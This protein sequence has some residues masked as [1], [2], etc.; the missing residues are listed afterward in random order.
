MYIITYEIS[1]KQKIHPMAFV[2][3]I[4]R[5]TANNGLSINCA[6]LIRTRVFSTNA[7]VFATKQ[8]T[9]Y[10]LTTNPPKTVNLWNHNNSTHTTTSLSNYGNADLNNTMSITNKLNVHAVNPRSSNFAHPF[11]TLITGPPPP[12]D[13]KKSNLRNMSGKEKLGAIK[14]NMLDHIRE[15]LF[16]QPMSDMGALTFLR[17]VYKTSSISITSSL[18]LAWTINKFGMSFMASPIIFGFGLAGLIGSGVAIRR[19]KYQILEDEKHGLY[20][21]NPLH[22]KIAHG[23]LCAS[24]GMMIA[25]F[26]PLIQMGFSPITF[27]VAIMSSISTTLGCFAYT[28]LRPHDA[29]SLWKGPVLGIMSGLALTNLI[30]GFGN[31][32]FGQNPVSIMLCSV[33]TYVAVFGFGAMLSTDT[34]NAWEKY[35][36]KNPDHLGAVTELY[37]SIVDIVS[38][39]FDMLISFFGRKTKSRLLSPKEKEQMEDKKSTVEKK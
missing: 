35:H 39:V 14:D 15:R 33:D 3:H 26:I 17:R 38:G 6:K 24:F 32:V 31:V 25:P 22:R 34:Y 10:T 27:P 13:E 37:L 12:K 2:R 5:L 21:V 7:S 11:R 28:Y 30:A 19:F 8:T 36:K 20:S 18:C 9:A 16:A 4:H 23:V 1:T 29:F